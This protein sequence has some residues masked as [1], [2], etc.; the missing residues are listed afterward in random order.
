ML[1]TWLTA[2][3][4]ICLLCVRIASFSTFAIN[5]TSVVELTPTMLSG[6]VFGIVNTVCR[7]L[8]I[9]APVIAELVPNPAWTVMVVGVV[10]VVCVQWFEK[11]TKE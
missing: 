1:A 11:G 5:Y 9:F 10:G 6:L 8:T 3:L 4:T 7:S 2:M